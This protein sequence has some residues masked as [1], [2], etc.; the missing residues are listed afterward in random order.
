MANIIKN[1]KFV[2]LISKATGVTP[3]SPTLLD[4]IIT[5][6]AD[7]IQSW[8]VVP[9]EIADHDLISITVDIR[10]LKDSL[11]CELFATSAII[12]EMPFA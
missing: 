3:N 2:Q 12:L 5:N 6:K 10:S 8:D 9:Q 11:S 7:T 1:T 4:L